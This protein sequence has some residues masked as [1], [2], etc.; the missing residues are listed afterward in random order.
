MMD[1][2]DAQTR[3]RMM[4]GIRSRNTKPEVLLRS[5]LHRK[6]YRFRIH[7][8]GLPGTP[9]FVLPRWRVAV[10]VHGCFWHR[11]PGCRKASTPAANAEFWQEKFRKN[12]ARDEAAL[13][14][15]HAMGWRT[16]VVWECSLNSA[17]ASQTADEAEEFVLQGAWLHRE[18][19]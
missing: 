17:R 4:S 13:Q 6:G 15:L 9:D 19:G 7:A 10:Q 3:S 11:H 18:I 5:L 2:V 16:L 14:A 12:V 1:I 8:R